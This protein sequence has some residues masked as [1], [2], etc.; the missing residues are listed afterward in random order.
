MTDVVDIAIPANGQI[1]AESLGLKV[2]RN[3]TTGARVRGIPR[4]EAEIAIAC[5]R[6][7]GFAARIVE[8]ASSALAPVGPGAKISR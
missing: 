6:D 4:E 3:V 7:L 8:A 2:E 5:L 1:A